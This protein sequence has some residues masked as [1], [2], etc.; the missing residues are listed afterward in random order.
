MKIDLSGFGN[1]ESEA[2]QTVLSGIADAENTFENLNKIIPVDTILNI[3]KTFDY[4]APAI[5]LT[6]IRIKE[7][8]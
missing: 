8:N 4:L 3:S 7:K 5:S 6:V 1:V 2:I